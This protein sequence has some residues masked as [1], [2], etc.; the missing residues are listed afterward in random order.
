VRAAV[1]RTHQ[2]RRDLQFLCI[3]ERGLSVHH[4]IL[5]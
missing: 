4:A 3:G 2:L 1:E 5:Y